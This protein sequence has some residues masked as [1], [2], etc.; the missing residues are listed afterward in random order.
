[1][2]VSLPLLLLLLAAAAVPLRADA[3]PTRVTVGPMKTSIYVGSV[4][5]TMTPFVQKGDGFESSY[6]ASVFPW[7]FWGESGPITIRLPQSDLERLARRETVEFT[8]DASNHKG[9]PRTITGRAQPADATSGKIKVRIMADGI[10]LIFNGTY[11]FG[12]DA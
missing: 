8:G 6:E 5:L 11:A 9:K 3:A 12:Q 2:R 1:M 4:T 10:E 7:F